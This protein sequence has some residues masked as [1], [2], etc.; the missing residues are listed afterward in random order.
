MQG[1]NF[2]RVSL[3][4]GEMMKVVWSMAATGSLIALYWAAASFE[5]CAIGF[6][7]ALAVICMAG[8]IAITAAVK[9]DK[10]CGDSLTDI[11]NRPAERAFRQGR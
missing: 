8:A 5:S 2:G 6:G 10:L 7:Q 1:D 4:V 3:K 9:L 11:K